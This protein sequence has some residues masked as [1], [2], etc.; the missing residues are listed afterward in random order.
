MTESTTPRAVFF[1][2]E[3]DKIIILDIATELEGQ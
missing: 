3:G 1:E 2:K